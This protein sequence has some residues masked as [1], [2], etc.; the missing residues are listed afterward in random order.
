[1]TEMSG[2]SGRS[3]PMRLHEFQLGEF[4]FGQRSADSTHGG[5]KNITDF[6][7]EA[8]E[9]EGTSVVLRRRCCLSVR[10][11]AAAVTVW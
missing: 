6:L 1:M 4:A 3:R 9:R 8:V 7:F 11:R 2:P 5:E 10:K